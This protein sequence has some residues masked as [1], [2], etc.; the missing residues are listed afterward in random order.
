[1]TKQM[2][3]YDRV[4]AVSSDGHR[5]LSV[6]DAGHFGFAAGI[7]HVPLMLGEFAAAGAEMPIVFAGGAGDRIPVAVLGFR[8][9]ENRFLDAAGAWRG[10]YVPAFLRRYPFVF[11]STGPDT[12]TLCLDESYPGCNR[13]GRGERL[14]DSDGRHTTYLRTVLGFMQ[15]YEQQHA[16]T[17]AFCARLDALGLLEPAQARWTP[18]S[19]ET[20]SLSGFATI[21]RTKLKALPADTLAGLAADDLL[22]PAFA[23]LLSLGRFEALAGMATVSAAA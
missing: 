18:P 17:R 6:R 2:L 19:G 10:R 23:Q 4:A 1:M 5:D 8:D 12:M 14:F 22:E 7:N 9:G 20:L 21:D 3:I 11:A 13:D 16:A 15:A